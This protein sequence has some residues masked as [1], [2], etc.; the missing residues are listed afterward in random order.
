MIILTRYRLDNKTDGGQRR[1]FVLCENSTVWIAGVGINTVV[2][3]RSLPAPSEAPLRYDNERRHVFLFDSNVFRAF[4]PVEPDYVGRNIKCLQF[5]PQTLEIRSEEVKDPKN[6]KAV[7]V[8]YKL[9]DELRSQLRA[10]EA[11]QNGLLGFFNTHLTDLSLGLS[12]GK[13]RTAHDCGYTLSYRRR[14]DVILA[15]LKARSALMARWAFVA[16]LA[17]IAR[18]HEPHDIDQPEW[19]TRAIEVGAL[20][21]EIWNNIRRS[22]VFSREGERVGGYVEMLLGVRGGDANGEGGTQWLA[23]LEDIT[24]RMYRLPLWLIYRNKNIPASPQYALARKY[25]PTDSD[26]KYLRT[27]YEMMHANE[28]PVVLPRLYVPG[29]HPPGRQGKSFYEYRDQLGVWLAQRKE[30]AGQAEMEHGAKVEAEHLVN[31]PKG[32]H[33]VVYFW[34]VVR[35]ADGEERWVTPIRLDNRRLIAPCWAQTIP[36]GRVYN[37]FNDEWDICPDVLAHGRAGVPQDQIFA[38]DNAEGPAG[39]EMT[40]GRR[41]YMICFV[42]LI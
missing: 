28:Q 21:V 14:H 26:F 42:V 6:P 38:V 22:W 24:R 20:T 31:P 12:I 16:L 5:S 27:E 15:A 11:L 30:T 37:M 7:M 41:S 18:M 34:E 19:T 39:E 4:V 1:N 23:Y 25:M 35:L 40:N 36:E 13:Y 29:Q 10:A 8:V 32:T 2:T 3:P 33:A 9:N 17:C